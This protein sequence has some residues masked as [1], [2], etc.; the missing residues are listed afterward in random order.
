MVDDIT[1]GCINDVVPYGMKPNWSNVK[2]Q[3]KK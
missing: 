3:M 2:N 1:I